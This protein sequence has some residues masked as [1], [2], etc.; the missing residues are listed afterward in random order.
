MIISQQL[1]LSEEHIFQP[2][3]GQPIKGNEN[4]EKFQEIMHKN[5]IKEKQSII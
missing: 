5:F 4:N 1:I 2:K 3:K